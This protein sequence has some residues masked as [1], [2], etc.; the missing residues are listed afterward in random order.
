[1]P[2]LFLVCDARAG[3]S[4]VY[5]IGAAASQFAAG[6]NTLNN[7]TVVPG[8]NRLLV[9]GASDSHALDIATVTFNGTALTQIVETND[10][11]AVDSLWYLVLGTAASP[12]TGNIVITHAGGDREFISAIVFENV[13][14][15]A[16]ISGALS[17]LGA[18]PAVSL[19]VTSKA[20]DMVLDLI[21]V[22]R[23]PAAPT[24]TPTSGQTVFASQSGAL[25][26]GF[27][28]YK[29]SFQPGEATTLMSWTHN[30]NAFIQL[31]VNINLAAASDTTA[32]T[33]SS[34]VRKAP[35]QQ[36]V[37][38]DTVVFAVTFSENVIGVSAARFI[39]S[40]VSGNTVAG[41][42]TS[43]SGG[44]AVYDV[45]VNVTSGTGEFRLD[46]GN[47]VGEP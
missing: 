27:G 8:N 43:I 46:V 30:G 9:V 20:G 31:A 45:T 5:Q 12:T 14:Q 21:D 47:P 2:A 13:D 25:G 7:F 37:V 26:E 10:S 22:F 6:A 44:P 28:N 35:T 19:S 15:S 23:F 17:H 18:T 24:L 41:T 3:S 34:I 32:P 40:P 1:L 11:F 39:V 38:T 42:I 36:T 29:M 33:I 16:P 4:G